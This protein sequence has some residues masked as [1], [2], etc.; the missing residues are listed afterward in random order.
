M[1]NMEK[2]RAERGETRKIRSVMIG[3]GLNIVNAFSAYFLGFMGSLVILLGYEPDL[4]SMTWIIGSIIGQMPPSSLRIIPHLP[5]LV[6]AISLA[7][8]LCIQKFTKSPFK[9]AISILFL[10]MG[11]G[12][13]FLIALCCAMNE[14]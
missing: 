12:T 14:Y 1:E 5:I 4:G 7:V 9:R 11:I 6:I 10:L 3:I 8:L 2:Q 13:A